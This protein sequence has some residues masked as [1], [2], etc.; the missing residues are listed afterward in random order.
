MIHLVYVSTA[1]NEMDDDE[2]LSLLAQARDRNRRQGITGMLLYSNGNFFQVLEGEEK[3]V[4][5]V[6]D[7][8][9]KDKRNHWN[10]V[11]VKER[12]SERSFP[13]WSMGF[14][15]LSE[16]DL[17]SID[18]YSDFMSLTTQEISGNPSLVMGL[19]LQFRENA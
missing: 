10:I 1:L 9:L 2:L 3:D 8:I 7:S 4:G 12:I 11:I 19:L 16:N 15:K 13:N 17:R 14:R 18:G 6:Y 5:E